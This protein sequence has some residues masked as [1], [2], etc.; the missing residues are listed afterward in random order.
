[1]DAQTGRPV[2]GAIVVGCW[3]KGEG[4]PGLTYHVLVGLRETETD[5]AGRFE[6]ER[7]KWVNGLDDEN[8]VVYKF[9][10]LAG[11][12]QFVG[13]RADRRHDYKVPSSIKLEPYRE[14]VSHQDN[15]HF[16]NV[17]GPVRTGKR[18]QASP[19]DRA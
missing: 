2:E 17:A 19:G 6:L 1:M 15:Y 7:L 16:A 5:A 18:S 4:L 11:N 3:V 12:N 9:G 13:P 8:V 10:Y 14:G